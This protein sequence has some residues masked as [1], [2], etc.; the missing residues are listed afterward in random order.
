MN[1]NVNPNCSDCKACTTSIFSGFSAEQLSEISKEKSWHKIKKGEYIF[2]E[3]NTPNGLFCLFDGN[4]KI[5]KIDEEGKEQIVRLAK[6]GNFIGYRA[7][8]CNDIYHASAIAI[9]DVHLC[10]FKK[11]TYLGLLY[12]K[13]EIAAQTITTLSNDL[14]F[15][16][17]MMMNIA[18]KHAKG[19]IAE[20]I[21]VLEDF[22]GVYEKDQ[23][24]NTCF[25]REDIGHLAGTT[26][27]TT[28]RVLSDFSKER[29]VETIG[30]KLRILNKDKLLELSNRSELFHKK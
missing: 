12:S 13:P 10:Y 26:T 30:K 18:Q 11:E 27:E 14:R 15:A 5:S 3:G 16:E 9:E 25:K 20:I 22:Y 7:L 19:R 29:I 8:L 24:I 4:V 17:N 2:K 21:L 6:R 23:T 28:I 1:A